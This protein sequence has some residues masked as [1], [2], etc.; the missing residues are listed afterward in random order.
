MEKWQTHKLADCD[1]FIG[2]KLKSET[3]VNSVDKGVALNNGAYYATSKIFL[4]KSLK[5]FAMQEFIVIY[6]LHKG[7]RDIESIYIAWTLDQQLP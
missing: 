7:R 1:D 4:E 6:C 3:L 2:I 5:T